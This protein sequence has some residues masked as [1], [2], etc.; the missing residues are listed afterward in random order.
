MINLSLS[1][2]WKSAQHAQ[3]MHTQL[4]PRFSVTSSFTALA[5]IRRMKDLLL[6]VSCR[7]PSSDW[8]VWWSPTRKTGSYGTIIDS[9]HTLLK[10]VSK[11]IQRSCPLHHVETLCSKTRKKRV[12]ELW[13]ACQTVLLF[14]QRNTSW[15]RRTISSE[16]AHSKPLV[17]RHAPRSAWVWCHWV[18]S[19][20]IGGLFSK[21][22]STGVSYGNKSWRMAVSSFPARG[23]RRSYPRRTE[24]KFMLCR[25][26]SISPTL[27]VA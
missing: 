8:S 11:H 1:D 25:Q 23:S 4:D 20:T 14:F 16:A 18:T 12:L 2:C 21:C 26:G 9:T 3:L 10:C 13:H 27:A 19:M 7:W 6:R 17:V 24:G 5:M 22:R 15:S